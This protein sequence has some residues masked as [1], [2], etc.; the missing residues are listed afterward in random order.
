MAE[1]AL[2]S[3]KTR[4]QESPRTSITFGRTGSVTE[5]D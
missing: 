4:L 5:G 2:N 1:P 3:P